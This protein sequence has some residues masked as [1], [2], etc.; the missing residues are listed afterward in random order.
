MKNID[1]KKLLVLIVIVAVAIIA[2]IGTAKLFKNIGGPSKKV[3]EQIETRITEYFAKSSL[4]HSTIFSGVDLLYD[5][6][7]VEVKDINYG[8][9]IEVALLYANDNKIDLSVDNDDAEALKKLIK[10]EPTAYDAKK[11]REIIKD[12]YDIDFPEESIMANVDYVYNYYYINKDETLLKAE[13]GVHN[14]KNDES[15]LDF[16]AYDTKKGKDKDT[17][18]TTVAVAYVYTSAY[19]STYSKDK[20][21]TT[22]IEKDLKEKKFPKDKVDEFTK[23]EFVTKKVGDNYVLVSISKLK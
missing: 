11:I 6:D 16:Y 7:K 13:S 20:N 14:L 8:S 4:G 1:F 3:K 17:Y 9:M 22:I 19:G 21:G 2:I 10:V 5:K 15:S 12:L 18:V 23:Y